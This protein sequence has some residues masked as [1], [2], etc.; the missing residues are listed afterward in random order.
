MGEIK[1]VVIYPRPTDMEAFEKAYLEEHVP[2]AVEKIKGMSRFSAT[3]VLGT[4]DGGTPP[5]YRIAELYFPSM[6]ALQECV[7]SA[8][9]QEAVAHAFAISTGGPP[10][11]LVAEE[12]TT[13]F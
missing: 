5:F 12:E 9:T 3:K 11:V 13:T 8:G 6:E 1:I 7:A 10:I 4:P 2:L